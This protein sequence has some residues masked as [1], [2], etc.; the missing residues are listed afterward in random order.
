MP[1]PRLFICGDSF[2]EW[3]IPTIHWTDYLKEHYD[4]IILGERGSDNISILFQLG[5]L[6]EY[7]DGDRIIVY[8]SDPS[9]IQQLYKGKQKPKLNG[10]WWDYS[11][12]F[13]KDR[14]PTLEK[15]KVDRTLGWERNGL[16]DEIK[17]IKKVKHLLFQYEP[18]YVTWNKFF[19]HNTKAFVDLIEVST[20]DDESGDG[21]TLGDW[22]PGKQGCYDIYKI[23]LN[24][25]GNHIPSPIKIDL[26]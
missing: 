6:P 25:L 10:R 13:E 14:I 5:N 4:V 18:I 9:R 11:H 20:L 8:W 1:K 17:F 3:D 26:L 19:Y 22:H 24:K 21:E 23:L 12:L 16:G 15:M 2:V 7:K